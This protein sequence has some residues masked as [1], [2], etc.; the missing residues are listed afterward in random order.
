M[1]KQIFDKY[2]SIQAELQQKNS[3]FN[4]AN[5][6]LEQEIKSLEQELSNR[7]KAF[8]ESIKDLVEEKDS[9]TK[10]FTKSGR[11]IL[12]KI[13]KLIGS[14][15]GW[16]YPKEAVPGFGII[17]EIVEDE[18]TFDPDQSNFNITRCKLD[19]IEEINDTYVKFYAE[20]IWSDGWLTGYIRVPIEYFITDCLDDK[21]YIKSIYDKIDSKIADRRNAEKADEIAELEAKLAELKGEK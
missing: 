8:D 10:D 21:S 4:K 5:E 13:G 17:R 3:E 20:E 15:Y 14:K 12:N 2:V 6:F 11:D 18:D 9:F 16:Y 7:R 19:R 1:E